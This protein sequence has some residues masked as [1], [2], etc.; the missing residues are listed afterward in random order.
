MESHG[1]PGGLKSTQDE[2][3]I[4]IN[5]N[6]TFRN[7]VLEDVIHH[8]LESGRTVCEAEVHDKGFIEAVVGSEGC[9]PLVNL[10]YSDV[11]ETP[12][13]VQLGEVLG[14]LQFHNK[15]QNEWKQ[16]LILSTLL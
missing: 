6:Y 14:P 5:H 8:H 10:L 13:N 2:D 12:L 3:V 15:L 9:L 11:I 4:Q 16:V 7:E 1:L